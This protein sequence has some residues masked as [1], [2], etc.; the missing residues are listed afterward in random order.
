MPQELLGPDDR[1][2]DEYVCVRK[3][4]TYSGEPFCYA[5]MYVPTLVFETKPK[6]SAKNRKLL[7]AVLE[8]LANHPSGAK[9]FHWTSSARLLPHA[10]RCREDMIWRFCPYQALGL[11]RFPGT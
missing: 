6:D 2:A 8:E 3:L 5:E 7:A 9:P 10:Y 1:P 4:H 11:S